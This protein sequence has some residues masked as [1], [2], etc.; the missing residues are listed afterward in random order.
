MAETATS[1]TITG[2][3]LLAFR[4]IMGEAG[5][6]QQALAESIGITSSAI[7]QLKSGDNASI[8]PEPIARLCELYLDYSLE[9]IM[10][11]R[12]EMKVSQEEKAD[13]RI[14]N[15]SKQLEELKEIL[16]DMLV[17]LLNEVLT[18]KGTVKPDLTTLVKNVSK[19]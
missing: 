14:D 17:P 3:F 15:I 5:L 7:S 2:R 6:R 8:R 11:G 9:W 4:H 18:A 12:G 10:L 13:L 16:G 19:S 1:E